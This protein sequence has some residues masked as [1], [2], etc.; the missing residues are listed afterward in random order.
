MSFGSWLKSLIKVPS[1]PT[2]ANWMDVVHDEL[3]QKEVPG[4]GNNPR[5]IFYHTFTSLHASEDAVAWCSS[6]AN[7]VMIKSGHKGTNSAAALS[8]RTYGSPVA[9]NEI[10]YGDICVFDWG[11]GHGH[12]TFFSRVLGSGIIECIG[13][14]QSDMVRASTYKLSSVAY[15]RR[16]Q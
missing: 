2:T 3:G 10:K 5:I 7:Y 8:W 16:P 15:I 13:G 14:N 9:P 12:V 4:P 6:F 1:I 11:N